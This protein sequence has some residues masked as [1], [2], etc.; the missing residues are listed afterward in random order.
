MGDG[1]ESDNGD[2]VF[3]R[4]ESP[5]HQTN[6]MTALEIQMLKQQVAELSKDEKFQF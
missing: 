4:G 5:T 3:V 2:G 6:Q 1:S